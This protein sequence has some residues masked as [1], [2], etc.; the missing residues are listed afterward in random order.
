MMLTLLFESVYNKNMY[1]NDWSK[2]QLKD[3]EDCAQTCHQATYITLSIIKLS[4]ILYSN[5]CIAT[6]VHITEQ[7]LKGKESIPDNRIESILNQKSKSVPFVC[8]Y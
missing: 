4:L 3:K 1:M 7:K 6:N 8:L 5:G 2:R